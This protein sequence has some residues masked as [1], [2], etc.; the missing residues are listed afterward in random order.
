MPSNPLRGPRAAR[1]TRALLAATAAGAVLAVAAC[2]GQSA[3]TEQGATIE[4]EDNNGTQTVPSPPTSVVATD[5]RTFET[6]S[7]WGVELSAGAVSL[8]PSTIPYTED[9][10]I[11]DL[12]SHREPDLEAVVAAEPDLIVNG[13]R[14]SQYHDDFVELVPE[15]TILELDPREG[16]P[17]DTELARQ[18]TV[19]GEVFDKQD[20][21]QTLV[22]DFEAAIERASAAYDGQS[23]VMAV[24]TSGG[25]IGYS[26][27]G[28][29]RTLG[30]VFD[31][32][33]LTPALE[34]EDASTDHQGDEI[35][36]EA[37]ADSDPDWILV[38]DRDAAVMADDP[39]YTPAAE[40]LEGSAALTNVTAVQSDQIVYM[41]ADTYT[42]EGIQTY[43]EFFN[44]LADAFEAAS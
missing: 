37:I 5:N 28:E 34:V 29:G 14:F 6:L 1:T 26:A 7:D 4:V 17:F 32:L 13:Q 21:A 2:G 3:S 33:D 19:L 16:E 23:T 27:P 18:V 41:P 15:A 43:T 8:M 30:P 38:M 44:T 12:G 10:S 22:E 24:I 40:V 31:I 25:Q 36:V 11:V 9:D 39:E 42:N 20:E 35:S